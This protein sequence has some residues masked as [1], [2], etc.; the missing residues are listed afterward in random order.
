MVESCLQRWCLVPDG[1]GFATHS[2]DMQPARTGWGAPVM[3]KLPREPHEIRGSALMHWWNGD[4]AATVLALDSE[5]GALLLERA[6]GLR[7]LADMARCDAA[8][9]DGASRILCAVAA[10]LHAPRPLPLPGLMPLRAWFADLWPQA[11]AHGGV[12]LPAADIALRLLD[13]PRDEAPL[14]GDLH[15]DNVLDFGADD[16]RAIDPHALAGERGFDFANLFSNPQPPGRA[17]S[18]VA[19]RPGRLARQVEVVAAAARLEH[20]R[21]LQWIVACSALSAAWILADGDDASLDLA[22]A[23]QALALL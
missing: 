20:T 23:E 5:S 18:E 4:G 3:L 21:L 15:H 14:H 12:F 2:S 6:L 16:W 13:D 22:V 10:R 8:G 17:E 1:P 19:L 7:S 11:R 9:D